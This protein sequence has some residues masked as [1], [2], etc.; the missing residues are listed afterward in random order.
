MGGRRL[1]YSHKKPRGEL[2]IRTHGVT[3]REYSI[4]LGK[5]VGIVTVGT[6]L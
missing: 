5:G 4:Y 1:L 6:A 2:K 3:V